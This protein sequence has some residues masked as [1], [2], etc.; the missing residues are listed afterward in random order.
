MNKLDKSLEDKLRAD[1]FSKMLPIDEKIG[2][3]H[4]FRYGG[5]YSIN[6]IQYGQLLGV[7]QGPSWEAKYKQVDWDTP[8][9]E[10]EDCAIIEALEESQRTAK[11][12]AFFAR[13]LE[14]V[15]DQNKDVLILGLQLE[16]ADNGYKQVTFSYKIDEKGSQ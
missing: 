13:Q 15:F 4:R 7:Y 11:A 2:Q 5:P 14:G 16:H 6:I 10:C 12:A 8:E 1:G 3:P 9:C